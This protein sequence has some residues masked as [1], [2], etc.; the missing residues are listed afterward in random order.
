MQLMTLKFKLPDDDD[1]NNEKYFQGHFPISASNPDHIREILYFGIWRVHLT[2]CNQSDQE[3][4]NIHWQE[5][6]EH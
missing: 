1:R 5:Y 6:S 4:K 2:F 3:D